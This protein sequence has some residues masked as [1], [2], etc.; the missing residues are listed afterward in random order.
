MTTPI[1]YAMN[2]PPGDRQPFPG[3]FA[4]TTPVD[5]PYPVPLVEG[6]CHDFARIA[7]SCL[8]IENDEHHERVLR[9]IEILLE[10]A[11][12]TPRDPL[13]AI[14]D[15]LSRAVESYE[16]KDKELAVFEKRAGEQT[17]ELAM[18]RLLMDQYGLGMGEL[19]EIGSI[20]M[21]SRVLSGERNLSKKHIQALSA[22][23]GIDP[24]M[25]F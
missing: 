13:N 4:D 7:A 1:P 15:M 24:G 8:Y 22:R 16:N 21:V 9:L 19:P 11:N 14:I 10:K 18:V 2:T 25:F 5:R 6:A 17:A 12:D 3:Y 20:S 23:F